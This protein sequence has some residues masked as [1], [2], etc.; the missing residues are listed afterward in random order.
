MLI[1]ALEGIGIEC[2]SGNTD[3]VISKYPVGRHAEVRAL[4][5]QW[6]AWTGYKTEETR[7]KAVYSNDVNNYVAVKEK[8]NPES[9]YLD[10]R[11]GCKTKG[12]YSERGSALNSPLSKNPDALVCIDAVLRFL[13][14]GTPLEQ[15]IRGCTDFRRFVSVRSVKAPGGE[16]N[17]KYLGKVVRWYYPVNEAGY[18]AYVKTGNKVAKTE[19]ARPVMDMPTVFPSDINYERY[20]EIATD[21]LFD[22]GRFE[23]TKLGQ[24]WG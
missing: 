13:V 2:I 10:E 19:G 20:I 6:E 8:G 12:S 7:Y 22:C 14:N 1:E 5:A 21:M 15:T 17:G 18:I 3:G 9:R 23:V 24:L 11:L 4:I 16:K